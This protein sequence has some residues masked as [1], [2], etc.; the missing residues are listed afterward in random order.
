MTGRCKCSNS[1]TC[2]IIDT[3]IFGWTEDY[4]LNLKDL[5]RNGK[6]RRTICCIEDSSNSSNERNLF[7]F[8]LNLELSLDKTQQNTGIKMCNSCIFVS[9][10]IIKTQQNIIKKL[11]KI[12]IDLLEKPSKK[13]RYT[14][15][16][17]RMY[18]DA[19]VKACSTLELTGAGLIHTKVK[20][21]KIRLASKK[22]KDKERK[23]FINSLLTLLLVHKLYKEVVCNKR[24]YDKV[25]KRYKD[26]ANSLLECVCFVNPYGGCEKFKDCCDILNKPGSNLNDDLHI[27]DCIARCIDLNMK[28]IIIVM[29]L[30]QKEVYYAREFEKCINEDVRVRRSLSVKFLCCPGSCV[31]KDSGVCLY[32]L[33]HIDDYEKCDVRCD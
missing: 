25:C 20:L 21:A 31:G 29:A 32:F 19:L 2:Y 8:I 11:V 12:I 16:S 10:T 5:D 9:S 7:S 14:N 24:S 3:S 30:G 23:M 6:L 18:K 1:G 13:F 33:R 26:Y 17:I 22:S 28:N 4:L 27:L 15:E